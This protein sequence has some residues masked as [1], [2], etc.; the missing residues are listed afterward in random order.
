MLAPLL[1]RVDGEERAPHACL[2]SCMLPLIRSPFLAPLSL[3]PLLVAPLASAVLARV[4]RASSDCS[5]SPRSSHSSS[6]LS[7]DSSHL[8]VLSLL[9]Q[10]VALTWARMCA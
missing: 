6:H 5:L 7:S 8:S 9:L 2:P 4:T 3:S 1:R 10:P